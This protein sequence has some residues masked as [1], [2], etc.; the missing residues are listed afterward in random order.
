M[1]IWN[2]KDNLKLTVEYVIDTIDYL[3]LGEFVQWTQD[4]SMSA[5]GNPEEVGKE[6]YSYLTSTQRLRFHTM[7]KSGEF[8]VQLMDPEVL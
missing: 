1:A 4:Q 5:L 6:E 8:R 7:V 3:N 2:L